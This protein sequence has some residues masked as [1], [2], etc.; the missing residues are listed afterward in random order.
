MILLYF[1]SPASSVTCYAC[2]KGQVTPTGD[3]Q[4]SGQTQYCQEQEWCFKQWRGQE[5]N[6]TGRRGSN[7]LTDHRNKLYV[8][9]YSIIAIKYIWTGQ[10][11]ISNLG[12]YSHKYDFVKI[13]LQC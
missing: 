4:E 10:D 5:D 13:R 1:V 12:Q 7:I 6:L 9:Y 8:S 3:C 11:I 2:N